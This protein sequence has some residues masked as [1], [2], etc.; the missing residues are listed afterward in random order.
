MMKNVMFLFAFAGSAL[1]SFN[2]FAEQT[3]AKSN[4]QG[5]VQ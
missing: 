3:L 4:H 5:Q 1:V 2:L